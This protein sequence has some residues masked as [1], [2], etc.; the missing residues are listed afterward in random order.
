MEFFFGGLLELGDIMGG[1]AEFI[2]ILGGLP[3]LFVEETVVLPSLKFS[4]RTLNTE[5]DNRI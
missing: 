5:L 2:I 1:D 4:P 3:G